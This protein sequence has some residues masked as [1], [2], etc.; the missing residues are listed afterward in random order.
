MGFEEVNLGFLYFESFLNCL[1]VFEEFP[2]DLKP[3]GNSVK[4]QEFLEK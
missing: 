4:L 3:I 1:G 2:V